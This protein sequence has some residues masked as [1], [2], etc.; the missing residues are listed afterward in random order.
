M[1]ILIPIY[2]IDYALRV[3][4]R[5]Y[6]VY[7]TSN[8][9]PSTLEPRPRKTSLTFALIVKPAEFPA[10]VLFVVELRKPV[11]DSS[12]FGWNVKLGVGSG[13][14][15]GSVRQNHHRKPLHWRSQKPCLYSFYI[16]FLYIV[17]IG[18]YSTRSEITCTESYVSFFGGTD[19][20]LFTYYIQR[21]LYPSRSIDRQ[22]Q[23]LRNY[24]GLL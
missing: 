20:G 2:N 17:F 19:K 15:P 7:S 12:Q 22:L 23:Y 11:V 5:L 13:V 21:R 18:F 10:A 9:L 4:Y 3:P 16:Q 14:R 24:Y 1:V 8:N 6:P